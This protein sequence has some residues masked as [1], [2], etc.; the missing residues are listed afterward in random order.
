MKIIIFG[1]TGTIGQQLVKQALDA[2]HIVTA[3]TRNADKL[4]HIQHTNLNIFTGDVLNP[5]KVNASVKEQDTVLCT[6]G[7]GRKG[8]VRSVGTKNIIAAMDKAGISRFICQTTLGCGESKGNLNF[9]WKKIMFGWFLKH[10]FIDHELQEKEI[11]NSKTNWTI[12][13]PGA[14]TNGALTTNYR[15][16]FMPDDKSIKL[17][18]SRADVSHFMLQQ[19]QS[20]NYLHKAVG[21]SY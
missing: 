6:L 20:N 15:Q 13:R 12:V 17:K 8:I 7:A 9:F 3:F 2:G 4:K 10:A 19:I 21:I 16:G 18:I 11:K 1:S 5:E 14:F